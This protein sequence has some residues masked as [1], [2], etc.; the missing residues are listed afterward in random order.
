MFIYIRHNCAFQGNSKKKIVNNFCVLELQTLKF[1]TQKETMVMQLSAASPSLNFHSG[2]SPVKKIT[3]FTFKQF[4]PTYFLCQYT[5]HVKL[6]RLSQKLWVRV[7]QGKDFA[8]MAAI[9]IS[10]REIAAKKHFFFFIFNKLENC[11]TSLNNNVYWQR[12]LNQEFLMYVFVK[13]FI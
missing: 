12:S 5:F 3:V 1:L 7:F 4:V 11:F 6:R 10:C 13:I 2:K 9:N 8:F